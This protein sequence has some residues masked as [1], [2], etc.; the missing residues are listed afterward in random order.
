MNTS[1]DKGTPGLR[2][3]QSP[4]IPSSSRFI[5][6]SPTVSP[7]LDASKSYT[8]SKESF[9]KV[10]GGQDNNKIEGFEDKMDLKK[11]VNLFQNT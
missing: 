5:K 1:S 10:D 2:T 6:R 4:G 8:Q 9:G 11:E 3:Q 7:R